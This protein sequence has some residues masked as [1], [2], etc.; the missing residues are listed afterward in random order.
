MAEA[1]LPCFINQ[2]KCL[3][4]DDNDVLFKVD[5]IADDLAY[6]YHNELLLLVD[7]SNK[8]S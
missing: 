7:N 8:M 1:V 5:K 2:N 3:I 4:T 6:I